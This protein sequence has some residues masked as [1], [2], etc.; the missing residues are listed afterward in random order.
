MNIVDILNEIFD[1]VDKRLQ[2]DIYYPTEAF[3]QNNRVI[4]RV[5]TSPTKTSDGWLEWKK[6]DIV[7]DE[8]VFL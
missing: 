4:V 1:T 7:V 8:D 2:G 5:Y 6:R 3:M